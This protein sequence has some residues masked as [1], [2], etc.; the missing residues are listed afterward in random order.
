MSEHLPTKEAKLRLSDDENSH[1][2][3]SSA[4]SKRK[5]LLPLL[6]SDDEDEANNDEDL[7]SIKSDDESEAEVK[8]PT[9]FFEKEAELSGSELGSDDEREDEEDEWEMEEGDKEDIDEDEVRE[10][11]ERAHLKTMLDEDQRE[12]RLFQELFLEDGDLHAEGGGRKKQFKWNA[13]EGF[14]REPSQ[15]ENNPEEP[16]ACDGPDEAAWRKA[17]NEREKWLQ[18]KGMVLSILLKFSHISNTFYLVGCDGRCK[19]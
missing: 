15:D 14:E 16:D 11:V 4:K 7:Q 9:D 6:L 13:S 10:Q 18:E 3:H 5:K 8:A 1:P 12:V 2:D 17:K 19:V